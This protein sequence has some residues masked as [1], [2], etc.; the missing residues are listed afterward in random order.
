VVYPSQSASVTVIFESVDEQY[1]ALEAR[2][3]RNAAMRSGRENIVA[4]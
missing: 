4:D 2:A 3:G 1:F